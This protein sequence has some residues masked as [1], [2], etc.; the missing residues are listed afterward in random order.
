VNLS[1]ASLR[2]RSRRF[3]VGLTAILVG[4][5]GFALIFQSKLTI[6]PGV[7]EVP[8]GLRFFVPGSILLILGGLVAVIG[9]LMPMRR[10]LMFCV[11][12]DAKTNHFRADP[13]FKDGKKIGDSYVCETCGQKYLIPNPLESSHEAGNSDGAFTKDTG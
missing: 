9:S 5:L 1:K 12:C 11:F 8:P 13:R 4:L 3:L 10:E 7:S 2:H 6:R